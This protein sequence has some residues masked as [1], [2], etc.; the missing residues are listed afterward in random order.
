LEYGTCGL[1]VSS[2]ITPSFAV[3]A[4]ITSMT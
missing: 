1:N 3:G 4:F 2:G